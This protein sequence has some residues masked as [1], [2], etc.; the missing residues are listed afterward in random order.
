M[1]FI[2][3]W[4]IDIDAV[5]VAMSCFQLLCEEADIRCSAEDLNVTYRLP[6]YHIY[7]ELANASKI[8]TTGWPFIC[9][10]SFVVCLRN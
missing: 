9:S 8:L 7:E 1:F 5:L 10:I 6:N 2:Y 3:I 4:S